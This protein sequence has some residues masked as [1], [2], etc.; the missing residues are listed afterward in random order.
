MTNTATKPKGAQ[1]TKCLTDTC[2]NMIVPTGKKGRP[3]LYCPACKPAAAGAKNGSTR[4]WRVDD[5]GVAAIAKHLNLQHPVYIKGSKGISRLGAYH[6]LRFGME[7]HKSLPPLQK[8]H[9][10]TVSA[11]VTPEQAS[12]TICHEM[13]HAAQAERD[14]DFHKKYKKEMVTR[15]CRSGNRSTSAH[16]RY[17]AIPYEREAQKNEG[18]HDTVAVCAAPNTGWSMKVWDKNPRIVGA[19]KH[20]GVVVR[21]GLYS[22]TENAPVRIAAAQEAWENEAEQEVARLEGRL[23][24][25]KQPVWTL[26]G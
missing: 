18:L 19:S 15:R 10:V 11:R 1:P 2:D 3:P 21:K 24:L 23:P 7:I 6:G 16:A 8:Y 12:R 13:T 26:V 4:P 5:D 22:L 20:K 17:E 9:L 14:P 25:P